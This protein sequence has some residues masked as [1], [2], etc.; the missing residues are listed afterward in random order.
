VIDYTNGIKFKEMSSQEAFQTM[1]DWKQAGG[2]FDFVGSIGSVISGIASGVVKVLSAAIS[3]I[4]DVVHERLVVVFGD[5]GEYLWQGI[6][7][8]ASHA[9]AIVSAV[10]D[11]TKWFGIRSPNGLAIFLIGLHI[12]G[13]PANSNLFSLWLVMT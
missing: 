6:A 1:T 9:A 2:F 11:K 3:V 12:R 13:R 7:S 10:L 5:A 4:G 8:I